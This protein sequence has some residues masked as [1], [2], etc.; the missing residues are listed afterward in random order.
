MRIGNLK[1]NMFFKNYKEL[2]GFLGIKV[3][4]GNSKQAQLNE[5]ARHCCL[6]KEGH[7]FRIK[8]VYATP[9]KE[10]ASKGRKGYYNELLQALVMDFLIRQNISEICLTRNNLLCKIE[11][12]QEHFVY[13]E[14]KLKL[15]QKEMSIPEGVL[16]DFF[17][18][19]NKT[20][21][22]ALELVLKKLMQKE[23][24]DYETTIIFAYQME[25]IS[26]L[27]YREATPQEL[28]DIKK[29][30]QQVREQFGYSSMK[31]ITF[32]K[33]RSKKFSAQVT[34]LYSEQHVSSEWKI[35][36]IY[37][38]YKINVNQLEE[39]K[40]L[41]YVIQDVTEKESLQY[42]LNQLL[43][44]QLLKNAEKRHQEALESDKTDFITKTRC[45]EKYVAEHE[46]LITRLIKQKETPPVT[47]ETN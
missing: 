15:L 17:N 3:V 27:L 36:F 26:K 29:V 16:Y 9:I 8:E 2:C 31:D 6:E 1:E 18:T 12:M 14:K 25:S 44:E 40:R 35:Q 24:I 30:E 7:S 34:R 13:D 37:S 47:L 11:V 21:K 39:E 41:T 10:K 19:T 28:H 4:G 43:C 46:E 42:Q 20:F 32:S 23:L 33:S 38:A 45:S 5:I 22:N